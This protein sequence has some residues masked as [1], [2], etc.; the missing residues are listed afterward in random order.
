MIPRAALA[1]ALTTGTAAGQEGCFAVTLQ[2]GA[3]GQVP[4]IAAALTARVGELGATVDGR[5]V[6]V[7]GSWDIAAR[8]ALFTAPGRLSFHAVDDNADTG[9][10]LIHDVAIDRAEVRVEVAGPALVLTRASRDAASPERI[11]TERVG[12][13]LAVAVDGAVIATPRVME[14]IRGGRLAISG[15]L[16]GLDPDDMSRGL[17]APLPLQLRIAVVD[18]VACAA[19]EK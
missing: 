7:P 16:G 10:A 12:R 2:G 13:A 4:A 5:T 14:P 19:G 17:A 18:R 15:G 3:A 8:E 1:L 11:T 6:T 9:A